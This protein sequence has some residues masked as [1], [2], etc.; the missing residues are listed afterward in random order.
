MKLISVL[1]WFTYGL[2]TS[3][4]TGEAGVTA[5]LLSL[6]ARVLF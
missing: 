3:K 6:V 4:V 5:A 1:I 2:L